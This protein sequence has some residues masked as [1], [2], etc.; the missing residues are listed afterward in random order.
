MEATDGRPLPRF[1]AGSSMKFDTLFDG[2]DAHM[3]GRPR[4][5]Q[6]ELE[7]LPDTH[8]AT[9]Q[10]IESLE[11]ALMR[12]QNFPSHPGG[13]ADDISSEQDDPAS[14]RHGWI[15]AVEAMQESARPNIELT[16]GDSRPG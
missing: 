7:D 4:I 8:T 6:L 12:V 1:K 2:S 11:Q 16:G 5:V 13:R 3:A 14:W 9:A 10:Y 15:C